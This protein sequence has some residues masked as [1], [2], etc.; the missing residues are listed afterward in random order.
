MTTQ[1]FLNAVCFDK[2]GEEKW[3]QYREG[4][5]IGKDE[6]GEIMIA[7]RRAKALTVRN[8]CVTG[9]ARTEFLRRMI[10]TL[11]CVY[12]KGQAYFFVLS[13][14]KE[15]GELLHLRSVEMTVPYIRGKDDLNEG[16]AALQELLRI[17]AN[18][19]G[20]P[21]LF[22]VLDGLE[23]L[24]DLQEGG[25][26]ASYCRIYEAFLR[27]PD[28]DFLTGVDL[29]KSIFA[30]FPGTFLGDG[31]CLVTTQERGRADV[32]YV[33]ADLSLT[34]P[35]LMTYPCEPSVTDSVSYLNALLAGRA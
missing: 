15:Y 19:S 9:G 28:V 22:V 11:S 34:Q 27:R 18:G 17:R 16:M 12:A 31:N 33:Q 3:E 14:Y 30:G 8:T 26:L 20:H 1:E 7:Q 24:P 32:T 6:K 4:L 35:E 2:H 21:R 25:E 13:P 29:S 5:P 10:I 23:E